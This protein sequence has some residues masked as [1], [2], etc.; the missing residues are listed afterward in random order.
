MGSKA[1]GSGRQ[2]MSRNS[3]SILTIH[4]DVK[5][6][7]KEQINVQTGQ[8]VATDADWGVVNFDLTETDY[9]LCPDHANGF[10]D[11]MHGVLIRKPIDDEDESDIGDPR[12]DWDGPRG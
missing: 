10:Q 6:C 1:S 11:F 2:Q 9:D 8:I 4:C 7:Q 3:S 5:G 12:T